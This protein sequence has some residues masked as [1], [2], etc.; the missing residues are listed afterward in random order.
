MN[1]DERLKKQ[2]LERIANRTPEIRSA[3]PKEM[4][5]SIPDV[6]LYEQLQAANQDAK[7]KMAGQLP[8]NISENLATI[9]KANEM[10]L[11][12]LG[13]I[14][15]ITEL[16]MDEVSR[17]ARAKE[18]GFKPKETWYH[19]S[20][21]TG[22]E[23]I[24]EFDPAKRGSLMM[25]PTAKE[26]FWFS[27]NP[28]VAEDYANVFE[29][30]KKPEQERILQNQ[31]Q[32]KS[33]YKELDRAKDELKKGQELYQP[34][35]EKYEQEIAKLDKN[36][37]QYYQKIRDLMMEDAKLGRDVYGWSSRVKGLEGDLRDQVKFIKQHKEE[38]SR[39]EKVGPNP[40]I[41]PVNLKTEN[42]MIVERKSPIPKSEAD[43]EYLNPN[44][45]QAQ[46]QRAKE[47][48]HDSVI[49]RNISDQP[50]TADKLIFDDVAAVFKP[51][52][53]RSKFA[54]FDPSKKGSGN[55]AAA[56][57]PVGLA[58]IQENK[59]EE[60]DPTLLKALK[61]RQLQEGADVS[62]PQQAIIP[63][64]GEST[65]PNALPYD[66]V[67]RQVLQ[68]L[69]GKS[70]ESIPSQTMPIITPEED[71][72]MKALSGKYIPKGF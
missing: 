2:I 5:Q 33:I 7:L 53:I 17:L 15:K 21:K 59:G 42:P 56:V 47:L 72:Q 20:P 52:Q 6:N 40:T 66:D 29:K 8:G 60:M 34:H 30:I 26:A 63:S 71:E 31:K 18:M 41:Y 3:T 12:T 58:T 22:P 32:I 48:G 4:I 23:G 54:K 9:D 36:D 62:I 70:P 10:A 37:P 39:L 57:G 44:D 35:L 14:K 38:I 46:I 51:E 67:R 64:S 24:Q 13:G 50:N 49:F 16:P 1:T 55:I 27:K 45:I 65:N 25:N 19:G 69:A 61:L 11:G 68:N 28:K 43:Y